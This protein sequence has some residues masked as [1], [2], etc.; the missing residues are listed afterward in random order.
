MGY[1]IFNSYLSTLVTNWGWK[2]ITTVLDTKTPFGFKDLVLAVLQESN[3]NSMPATCN[4]GN[5][6]SS[7]IFHEQNLLTRINFNFANK[8]WESN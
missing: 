6:H 7:R 8:E 1:G 3:G 5:T 4:R 2:E